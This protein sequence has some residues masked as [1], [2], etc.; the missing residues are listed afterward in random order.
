M[1]KL[2]AMHS[3]RLLLVIGLIFGIGIGNLLAQTTE[4]GPY[5]G[6]HIVSEA[7]QG[8]VWFAAAEAKC[9][10]N[11]S[12]AYSVPLHQGQFT[13]TLRIKDFGF[14]IPNN[15]VIEGLEVVVIRRSDLNGGMMD[16][17]AQL[18]QNNREVGKNLRTQEAWNNEWAAVYYGGA[19]E[20]WGLTLT[21]EDINNAN[22]GF[23]F[24]AENA[25]KTTRPEIDEVLVTV[26][27]SLPGKVWLM[28]KSKHKTKESHCTTL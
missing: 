20:T 12:K 11:D 1:R 21:P 5:C 25:G 19:S 23:A 26:H 18:I 28:V 4:V 8:Q 2:Y 22:F 17:K 15:A 24:Q 9:D 10:D 13:Q 6:R 16:K 7:G 14:E 3:H 27:Y